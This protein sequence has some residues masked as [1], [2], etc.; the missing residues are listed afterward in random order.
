MLPVAIRTATQRLAHLL[1]AGRENGP[2]CQMGREARLFK[3]KPKMG[4]KSRSLGLGIGDEVF[5]M[6]AEDP[7][8]QYPVVMI[9]ELHIAAI[10][11]AH[12]IEPIAELVTR[13]KQMHK[14]GKATGHGMTPYIDDR[15]PGKEQMDKPDMQEVVRRLVNEALA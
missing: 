14:I 2:S 11:A 3:L 1:G 10:K 9:H 6:E 7:T 13:T 12:L 8:W 5:I 15:R 4:E